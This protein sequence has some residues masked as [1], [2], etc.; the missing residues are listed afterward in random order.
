MAKYK[1]LGFEPVMTLEEVAKEMGITRQRVYA[2]EKS[3]LAKLAKMKKAQK[4]REEY[5]YHD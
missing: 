3:A 4:M 1:D 2:I 5:L